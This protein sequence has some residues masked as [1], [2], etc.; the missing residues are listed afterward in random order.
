MEN[1][2]SVVI[3]FYCNYET[4]MI[5]DLFQ[6]LVVRSTFLFKLLRNKKNFFY[7]SSKA[8]FNYQKIVFVQIFNVYMF[9]SSFNF[10]SLLDKFKFRSKLKERIQVYIFYKKGHIML[11]GIFNSEYFVQIINREIVFLKKIQTFLGLKKFVLNKSLPKTFR[12]KK[13]LMFNIIFKK[14]ILNSF[15]KHAILPLNFGWFEIKNLQLF[16]TRKI[17]LIKTRNLLQIKLFKIFLYFYFK[18]KIICSTFF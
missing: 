17:F 3:E 14:R 15:S 13:L 9:K 6:K 10:L 18:K 8:Y 7:H 12:V 5:F 2:I 4:Q 16:D 1:L 11:H